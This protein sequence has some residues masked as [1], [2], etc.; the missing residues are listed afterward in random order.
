MKHAC[1]RVSQLTSDQFER[2]L[3]LSEKMQLKWH[4]FICKLC[5][6]YDQS[7]RTLHD[8]FQHLREDDGHK[9][10]L[11]EDAKQRIQTAIQNEIDPS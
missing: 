6:N 3:T 9:T 10:Q 2:H 1:K 5:R 7:L 11:P 8:V 4:F